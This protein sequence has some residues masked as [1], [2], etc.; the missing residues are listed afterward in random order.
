MSD[1]PARASSLAAVPGWGT[2]TGELMKVLVPRERTPNEQRVAATPESVSRLS[3]AGFEVVFEA[4][5]GERAGFEDRAY[6]E[7]GGRVADDLVSAWATANIVVKVSPPTLHPALGKPEAEAMAE[8]SLFVGFAK[9]NLETEALRT[10]RDRGV[11]VLA[12]ELIPRTTRAQSMDALSSQ[13]SVAGYKAALVAAFHLNKYVPLMM[14]AA[15]TIQPARVVIM[16]AGV[17]GLQAL[18]TC[19]R[20]GATV[21][22]SDIREAVK[23]EVHSLGGRFI[24]L[25]MREQGEGAGGYA[26]EMT[27]EFLQK[28]REIVK[29]RLSAAD[30]AITTALVPGRR[31]PTLITADMVAGM[32]K[33]AVIVD[34]AVEQGGNCELSVAGETV[35]RHGV[36]IVGPPNLPATVPTDSSLMYA[37]NVQTLLQHLA[38]KGELN[39][40]L[41]DE[42]IGGA[43]M[44][45]RGEV[46]HAPTAALLE[47]PS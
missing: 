6:Q 40:D 45:H 20:L 8:G 21:E 10:L 35:V 25:P 19:R 13:A 12:M 23:E 33:G 1:L 11:S 7:A 27:A 43:L 16:G 31:A 24:E 5:C 30:A 29:E 2:W 14:T 42:I 38:P 37:R 46:R 44:I 17:A 18:A 15:G 36:T 26:K 41:E 34:L 22:V 32:K 28:Q 3:K 4:G 9:A 39:L 47:N